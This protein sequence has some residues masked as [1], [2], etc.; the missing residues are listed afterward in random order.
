MARSPQRVDQTV[1][2]DDFT[3]FE[4]RGDKFNVPPEL[5]PEGQ[6]YQWCRAYNMGKEDTRNIANLQRNR[7]SFVPADREGHH[8]LGGE[9]TP[10]E[11]GQRHPFEGCILLEGLV[12]MERPEVIHRKARAFDRQRARDDR[13][14]KLASIKGVPAG[15][16]GGEDGKRVVNFQRHR[17]L[18]IPED[19][20]I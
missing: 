12:L 8:I 16:L 14:Q 11:G 6:V 18:S 1:D 3:P 15:H 5:V 7:W 17:D 19:A 4:E 10:P 13:D 9:R 2:Q 20:D